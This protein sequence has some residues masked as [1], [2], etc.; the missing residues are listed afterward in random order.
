MQYMYECTCTCMCVSCTCILFFILIY[1]ARKI[2]I[3]KFIHKKTN[4]MLVT[5][6]AVSLDCVYE[7]LTNHSCIN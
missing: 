3:G 5:D 6:V 1:I 4:V 7:T 2:S